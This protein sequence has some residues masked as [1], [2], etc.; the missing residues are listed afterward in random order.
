L[1]VISKAAVSRDNKDKSLSA[2]CFYA[3]RAKL[4]KDKKVA[5]NV[6]FTTKEDKLEYYIS[7]V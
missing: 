3:Y 7:L 4:N 1:C 5:L 2:L 6:D